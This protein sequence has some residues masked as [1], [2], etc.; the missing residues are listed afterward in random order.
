[1]ARRKQRLAG[2][3][4]PAF[5]LGQIERF[6]YYIDNIYIRKKGINYADS[7]FTENRYYAV[8]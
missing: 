6:T 5:L 4:F 3:N 2:I 7:I 1:M 8:K